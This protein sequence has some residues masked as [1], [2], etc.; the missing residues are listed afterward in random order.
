MKNNKLVII[1]SC[2]LLLLSLSLMIFF[3]LLPQNS[4]KNILRV[5][6]NDLSL[7]VG[8]KIENFYTVSMKDTFI[9]FEIENENVIKIEDDCMY[10]LDAGKTNVTIIAEKDGKQ[11]KTII[12][13]L[14]FNN[15]YCYSVITVDNC[16]FSENT[17]FC[18]SNICQFR[19]EIYDK[20]NN[21]MTDY[22]L[23]YNCDKAKITKEFLN[24]K[25]EVEEDCQIL[26]TLQD[27]DFDFLINVVISF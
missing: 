8:E 3:F 7:L 11:A 14:V 1:T 19:V 4:E 23:S 21:L 15:D 5:Y 2:V 16:E 20:N 13:V 25:I 18:F 22:D 26:F 6:A 10:A 17:L 12:N 24:Y 27:V 9:K